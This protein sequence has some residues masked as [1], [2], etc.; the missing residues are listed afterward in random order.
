M[1]RREIVKI[2]EKEI[3]LKELTVIE[4]LYIS[5]R[6]GWIGETPGVSFEG[7]FEKQ[8]LMSL[9]DLILSFASDIS[10]EEAV[11]LAPSEIQKLYVTFME[12]NN[13]TLLAAK[14]LGIDKVFEEMKKEL[15][16]VFVAGYADFAVAN[17]NSK[18]AKAAVI[19]EEAGDRTIE[20]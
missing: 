15:V 5:H 6:I 16:K 8:K 3:T 4:L 11:L 14:R 9:P 17:I 12:M 1:K 2:D 20:K 10:K 19:S 13:A 7:K 18:E